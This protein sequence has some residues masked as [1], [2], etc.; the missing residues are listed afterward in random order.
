MKTISLTTIIIFF[1]LS[2]FSQ[3]ITW[4]WT[5]TLS[6]THENFSQ[7][8]LLD[9]NQN[10]YVLGCFKDTLAFES[11]SIFSS[12]V[13][14]F[15]LVK[16]DNTG[17]Y[18]WVRDFTVGFYM[19][20]DMMLDSDGNIYLGLSY[21]GGLTMFDG[22]TTNNPGFI[23]KFNPQG[24]LIWS[25][26]IANSSN[27]GILIKSLEYG[28]NGEILVGGTFSN[29]MAIDTISRTGSAGMINSYV[30]VMDTAGNATKCTIVSVDDEMAGVGGLVEI[31]TDLNGW[32][33]LLHNTGNYDLGNGVFVPSCYGMTIARFNTLGLCQWAVSSQEWVDI[34]DFYCDNQNIYITGVYSSTLTVDT[35]A[36]SNVGGN[37]GMFVLKMNQDGHTLWIKGYNDE[38]TDTEM[39]VCIAADF[40]KNIYIMAGFNGTS[41]LGNDTLTANGYTVADGAWDD[42]ILCKMDSMGN[43]VWA[44]NGGDIANRNMGSI[45][46]SIEGDVY[47]VGYTL[48]SNFKSI[49]VKNSFLARIDN[50]NPPGSAGIITPFSVCENSTGVEFTLPEVINADTYNWTLPAGMSGTSN[51]NTIL[52]DIA[53]GASSGT[54][55]V[56][57]INSNGVGESSDVLITVNSVPNTPVI[58]FNND[59]LYSDAS[60]GNQWYNS[61]GIIAGATDTI[62]IPAVSDTYYCIVT[63]TGCSSIPSNSIYVDVLS[64]NDMQNVKVAVYPNPCN[65][66]LRITGNQISSIEITDIMGNMVIKV[67]NINTNDYSLNLENLSS[68]IYNVNVFDYFGKNFIKFV[69]TE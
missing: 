39:G 37:T 62:Y 68:G 26:E 5:H 9:N 7:K 52:V 64:V 44:E 51:T 58:S 19:Y 57:A 1:S 47:F 12:G 34:S 38:D 35:C 63:E 15:F 13:F 2:L 56:Y 24:N 4:D 49:D 17:N 67:D 66:M 59:T 3:A 32:T 14:S 28:P 10:M 46:T 18:Q 54:I 50:T 40:N 20:S 45:Y 41:V 42:V 21:S 8:I 11:D 29:D 6:S 31:A 55:S 69:M 48:T 27:S 33:I 36:I 60:S 65:G 22:Y 23:A 61:S 16:F 43:P 53:Q 30:L 25:N